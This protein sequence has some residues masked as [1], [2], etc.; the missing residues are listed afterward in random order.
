MYL[1]FDDGSFIVV[2]IAV[3][4]SRKD[5]YNSRELFSP[6]PFIHLESLS[7]SLMSSD[8]RNYFVFLKKLFSQLTS[9]EVR[10]TSHIIVL[11]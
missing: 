8:H 5:C 10:A 4:R 1:E 9:K 3:V 11:Y 2:K 7:L 6:R